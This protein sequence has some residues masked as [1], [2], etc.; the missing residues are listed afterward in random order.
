MIL[1]N[2]DKFIRM[3]NEYLN[4][5]FNANLTFANERKALKRTDW[6]NHSIKN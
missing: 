5:I 4:D 3:Y 2:D 6:N 1:E